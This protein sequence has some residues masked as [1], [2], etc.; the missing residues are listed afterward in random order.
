MCCGELGAK[1]FQTLSSNYKP[2]VPLLYRKCLVPSRSKSLKTRSIANHCE[3]RQKS[4]LIWRQG[5]LLASGKSRRSTLSLCSRKFLEVELALQLFCS[6]KIYY[7]SFTTVGP[8][9]VPSS[10][11]TRLVTL[12]QLQLGV[13]EYLL[14]PT[15]LAL[16]YH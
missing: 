4:C 6:N 13:D 14:R 11:R 16:P 9:P 1:S 3:S 10:L 15:L 12:R 5:G 8:R 2:K 7:R